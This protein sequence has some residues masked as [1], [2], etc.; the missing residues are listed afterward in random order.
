MR[1]YAETV[2]AIRGFN[3]FYTVNMG[4]LNSTYL[5]TEYSVAATRILFELKLRGVCG[6]S[7][8]AKALHIDKSY[9]SRLIKDFDQKGLVVKER[10][11]DDKRASKITLTA[12]G[13]AE[14][15]RLIEL[16]NRRIAAQID[17]LRADECAELR[18]ALNTV[19]TILGKE[20]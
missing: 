13:N 15:E 3:R 9:L 18:R 8:I 14:T 7:D 2:S 4:L 5:D 6:Q 19:M 1:K 16:T 12:R 10:S 17:G 20:V 11:A